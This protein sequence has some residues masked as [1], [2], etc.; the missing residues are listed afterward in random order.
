MKNY[1]EILENIENKNECTVKISLNTVQKV[2]DFTN[3]IVKAT[4]DCDIVTESRRYIIDAKSIMGIFSLDLSTN[5]ILYIHAT[6]DAELNAV[7]D[8]V[9]DFAV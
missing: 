1:N 8:L 6:D 4:C 3:Q 2:K 9:K 7:R 5:L